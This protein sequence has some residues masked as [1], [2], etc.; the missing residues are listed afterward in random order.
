M[1]RN[2]EHLST[3]L[4]ANRGKMNA[5]K[6]YR[7]FGQVAAIALLAVAVGACG[8]DDDKGGLGEASGGELNVAPSPVIFSEVDLGASDTI[9]VTLSNLSA[10]GTLNINSVRLVEDTLDDPAG[11]E[12]ERGTEWFSTAQLGPGE[13]R[14]LEVIYR[15]NDEQN[16]SGKIE[17]DVVGDD[18]I[19]GIFEIPIQTAALDPDISTPNIVRFPRVAPV[20]AETIDKAFRTQEVQNIGAAPLSLE[21]VILTGSSD[22]KIRYYTENPGMDGTNEGAET[23]PA[24]L[25][26]GGSF[27]YRLYFNPDDPLPSTAEVSFFT[28]DPDEEIYVVDIEGNSDSPCLEFSNQ[29][30]I[31]FGQG[32]IGYANTKTVTI[33]NCGQSAELEVSNIAITDD[34]GAVFSIKS[35]TLPQEII[36]GETL[37]LEP[38]ERVNFVVTYTPIDETQ[39]TG[40]ITIE[41]ND[42]SKPSLAVPIIGRGTDN[43]CP[44]AIAQG[45]ISGGQPNTALATVPQTVVQLDGSQSIDPDGSITRYEW[46]IVSQPQGSEGI[47]LLPGPDVPNPSISVDAAGIYVIELTVF[48]DGGVASCGDPARVEITAIPTDDVHI[49]LVWMTPLDANLNDDSGTDLDLHFLHPLGQWNTPPYD[50][51]WDN[52]TADWGPPGAT[53]NPSLDLDD[54]NGAG[55]ENINLSGPETGLSYSI[56]VYYYNDS[57]FG[58]SYATVRVYVRGALSFEYRDVFLAERQDFWYVASLTWPSGQVSAVDRTQRGFP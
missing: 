48:D 19:S 10:T 27:W 9:S 55:P 13:S 2:C 6:K 30:E 7:W 28:N 53:G 33:R 49:Q 24:E 57:S 34:G 45:S 15:P 43:V 22:Y 35:D 17:L 37:V 31:N 4:E 8:D 50:I 39:S 44:T 25:A 40:E 41:S 46:S 32:G 47:R 12:F 58:A 16:D 14:V 1:N 26:P 38:G 20:S 23:W 11:N 3:V 18:S 56:G 29:D 36:D 52:P 21:S 5:F 54:T 42:S 51:F